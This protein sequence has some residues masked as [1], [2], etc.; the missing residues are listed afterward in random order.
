MVLED[1]Y[2][3]LFAQHPHPMWVF[4][5]ETLAF[6]EVNDAAVRSYGYSRDEFLTMRATE[7]GPADEPSR[8]RAKNGAAMD[9][10]VATQTVT[11]DG[12]PAVLVTAQDVTDRTA[13]EDQLR[14][15][16]K[17]EAI[18]Q[19]AGGIAH[20]LNNLLTAILGFSGFL[21]ESMADDD[22]RRQDV[23]EIKNAADRAAVLTRQLLAFGRKQI[24][25]TRVMHIGDVVGELTPMLRRLV[26][27]TIDLRTTIGDRGV[28]KADPGQLQQV[29]V[30]LAVNAR[31]AMPDGG[32]LT[33]ETSDAQIDDAFVRRHPGLQPGAHVLLQVRDT[34]HGM[35]DATLGR[36]FEPFFT[37]KPKG[38]GTGLGL[39]TVYGIVTQSGGAIWV[40]SEVGRGTTFS[41]CL[42]R[43]DEREATDG[44]HAATAPAGHGD[45]TVL[46]VEDED[47]VREFVYKVLTRKGYNVHALPDPQRAIEY[48][49]AHRA[50]I[51]LVF[52]DVVLP[53]MN[54]K[55]MVTRLRAGH[56][57]S[58]VLYMS[59]YDDN[60]IV[61]H[62]ILEIDTELLQKPFTADALARKVRDVL[63]A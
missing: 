45:E 3:V 61:Q 1:G 38:H 28:V 34:G 27:E 49:E 6:L 53:E 52:T 12:R 62:G 37:T 2:R 43:T 9:V 42:P 7:I 36:V 4:D 55:V 8:H 31:D 23:E 18:G 57:E 20:D 46:L 10:V 50:P 21:A 33:I 58:K 13:A 60:A 40:D 5:R 59:G 48:A 25:A 44:S 30:N 35:D 16:Q 41:V 14:Q 22:A 54:G 32:R 51:D 63:D 29:L 11:F 24:L 39:A 26:S 47:V 19:L 17:M 56:P 15:A